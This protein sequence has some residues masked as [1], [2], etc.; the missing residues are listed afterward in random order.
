MSTIT[1]QGPLRAGTAAA[2]GVAA[3]QAAPAPAYRLQPAVPPAGRG[4]LDRLAAWAE[5]AP[6]HRRLGSWSLRLR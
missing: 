3:G 2:R 5:A 4:W 1:L 6:Q